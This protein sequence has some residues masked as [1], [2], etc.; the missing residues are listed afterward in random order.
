MRRPL[1]IAASLLA[2]ACVL[3]TSADA[4]D[5]YTYEIEM[6]N[7]FGIV[8]GSDV[9]VAGVNAGSVTALDVNER[10]RAVVTVEVS[11]P[12][13]QLGEDTTCTTAPGSLIAE[14]FIDCQ[15][16]GP[17]ISADGDGEPDIPAEQV[18]GTVQLDLLF[19]TLREPYVERVRLLVDELGTALA[20][21]SDALGGA[22]DRAVPA[23][24]ELE[25]TTGILARERDS[26]A[27]LNVD[28]DRVIS[29]LARGRDDVVAAID[30]ARD[31]AAI[32][33]SRR[34][35][36]GR[37]AELL[38]D[39]VVE[40]RPTLA[41]LGELS[42]AGTPVLGNLRAA[43]P[44]LQRLARLLPPFADSSGDALDALGEASGPGIAALRQGR[45]ELEDLRRAT[46]NAPIDSEI[47]ADFLRDLDDPRRIVE[48]DERAARSCNDPTRTCWGT[49]RRG[50]TGYTGLE[51]MLRYVYYQSGA[52]NQFD[53][54][55]HLLQFNVYDTATGPC[56]PFNPGPTV[57][58]ADGGR[59]T[60]ILKA[61]PCVSWLGPNQADISYDLD[62]PRYDN[63]V[64]RHGS[65]DLELCDPR[66]STD[67]ID[68]APWD[69]SPGPGGRLAGGSAAA[70]GAERGEANPSDP[71]PE[72]GEDPS[73]PPP[74]GS[75]RPP[76]DGEI[77]APGGGG[78]PEIP[79]LDDLLG[80]AALGR[81]DRRQASS[82][83]TTDLLD[84]LLG[85]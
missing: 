5:S 38:D 73:R 80:G 85:A 57:P 53:S 59:T 18:T 72:D 30:E 67:P 10:K 26:L 78:L 24:S 40:L 20:G 6:F 56:G 51:A 46:R 79:G 7:A 66:I 41:R 21:N 74:G 82:A 4:D 47:L 60:E 65:T 83:A 17:A 68:R 9:R 81:E 71:D 61:D 36:L 1:L 44:S 22:L 23:L 43:A 37:G 48:I 62:L 16:A 25:D 27:A 70:G 39:M 58:A 19:N 2:G 50:P 28:A 52:I 13:A 54:V 45:D 11:G 76:G 63:S 75:P 77:P 55:G 3:V 42:R 32:T 84:Y 29:R 8:D 31:T 33:A 15:P 34:S 12:L 14:Y 64:C 69:T 49:G 35:D